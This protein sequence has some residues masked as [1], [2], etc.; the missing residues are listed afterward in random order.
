[1]NGLSKYPI[2]FKNIEVELQGVH[3]CEDLVF[4]EDNT[5]IFIEYKFKGF[6]INDTTQNNTWNIDINLISQDGV[7]TYTYKGSKQKLIKERVYILLTK[8]SDT[9]NVFIKI[10]S[11]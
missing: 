8:M 1:M 2:S 9:S 4:K 7:A 11:Y 6:I 5:M 10:N 3:L